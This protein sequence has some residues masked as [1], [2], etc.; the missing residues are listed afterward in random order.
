MTEESYV[1]TEVFELLSKKGF[2]LP[3]VN[4]AKTVCC[5][6]KMS[7]LVTQQMAARWLMEV[8]NLFIEVRIN[9]E[10]GTYIM[11]DAT[12]VNMATLSK[13]PVLGYNRYSYKD[14]VDAAI[15]KCTEII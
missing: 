5:K 4:S 6:G 12:I 7:V 9:A 11:F 15:K 13:Y 1:S 3:R 14:C 2:S 8:H 10:D